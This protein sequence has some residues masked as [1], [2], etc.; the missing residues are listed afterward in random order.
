M[1]KS[2][3]T[4][5]DL[6][7]HLTFKEATD[8][9]GVSKSYLYKLTHKNLIPY[10]KPGGKLIYFLKK[11]VDEWLFKNRIR[12]REQIEQEAIDRVT[13]KK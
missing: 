9:L 13:L 4:I 1:E 3:K 10:Y 11:D 8:Y 12:S 2:N 6:I 5:Y 7:N